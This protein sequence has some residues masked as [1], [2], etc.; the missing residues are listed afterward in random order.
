MRAPIFAYIEETRY[1][2]FMAPMHRKIARKAFAV[3]MFWLATLSPAF[4]QLT[5]NGVVDK[6]VYTD[7]V[8]FNVPAQAGY[9]Y[10]ILLNTNPVASGASV[11]VDQPDFYQLNVGRVE[12]A[13]GNVTNRL[14]RFIV[15]ASERGDTEWGLP[16]HTPLPVVNSSSNEFAGGLLRIMAPQNFPTGYEI[17][18][19][20]WIDNPEGHAIRG[21]GVLA[22]SGHPSIQIKRGVGSG[23]LG[24]TNSPGALAYNPQVG[25]LQ[26]NRT[27]HLESSTAWTSVSGPLSGNVSW[28]EDSRILV[29]TNLGIAAGATLTIGAGTIVRINPRVDITN[30]GSLVING[31]VDR[32][33]VFMPNS[34]A[35]PWGGFLMR[36]TT[37]EIRGSGAIFTGSGANP[38][39]FGASG[40]PSSHRTEQALFFCNGGQRIDLTDSAAIY[41]AGQLGHS[42]NATTTVNFNHFLMQR[43]T[44]G[45]EYTGANFTVNDSAFIE[46]PDD[47]SNFVD[48]DNDG[49]YLVNGTHFFTN[50]L[51]GWTKDD[52]IDSGGSGYGPLTYQSCWFEATFHEGNSLSG[53][54]NTF[55]HDTV[56]FD[57]GQGIEDGYNAPTGRVDHCLFAACEAGVR[58][59][60]NYPSIGNYDGYMTVTNCVLLYNHRDLFG[61]NWHTGGGWTNSAQLIANNNLLTLS[62]TNFPSNSVWDSSQDGWRLGSLGGVGQ[63]GIGFAVR[64]GPK[65]PANFPKGVPVGLSRFCTNRVT[66]DYA[67]DSTDGTHT[68]GQLVFPPGLTRSFIRLPGNLNGVLRIGLANAIHGEI[69]GNSA[70]LIQNVAPAGPPPSVL[71]PLGSSWRYLDDASNQGTAWKETA[72]NDA[73]W[74][75][76]PARLGF[77]PDAIATTT[78][79]KYLSGTSG[80]QI[81]NFY[82]RRS[83]IVT[84]P[85]DFATLQFRYQRDDGCIVYL[86]GT[87]VLT[88]NMPAGPVTYLTFAATTITPVAETQRF[89]TN[90]WPASLL[91]QGANVIASEV[92][93]STAT[94]SDIAWELE[95]QG[96]PAPA[97]VA[98]TA[99]RLGGDLLIYWSDANF[100][101]ESS[102]QVTGPWAA[103]A[104]ATSPWQVN[105]A[106]T[107][108]FFRL[109]KR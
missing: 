57:C 39:W 34:R 21:N 32:P 11:L 96:L 43:C 104:A 18:L 46:C 63:V 93:Q 29:T 19:V 54:K 102:D 45:G 60:D 23:F 91:R 108:K 97:Q 30:M 77:G 95:L 103:V 16:P 109:H 31:T 35:E 69:T 100:A 74:S 2:T 81:T 75:N 106:D 36:T 68:T 13:T 98:V 12:T 47:S 48:G 42:V 4:A 17:P 5:I 107:Q 87:P 65:T 33:V 88:N 73:G 38:S 24:A 8:T 41:L 83:I 82:F 62:D 50:S 44:T 76:G 72:F 58:H 105:P 49:I 20:C 99:S 94:S 90:T 9:T 84:N 55:A 3:A 71:S 70:L 59:G 56:Y 25:G 67:L 40:N 28:P 26:T 78:I 1:A 27:I 53:Y 6:T 80:P 85:A 89:W 7:A 79:R 86:N 15:V 52:G 10:S 101:L 66:V 61:Y 92:H 51:I 64:S 14:I 22:A 37:G